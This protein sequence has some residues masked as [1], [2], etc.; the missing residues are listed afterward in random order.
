MEFRKQPRSIA[1]L[2][3][4]GERQGEINSI[5]KVTYAERVWSTQSDLETVM[6]TAAAC[7]T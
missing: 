1:K 6:H 2:V 4:N 5:D 3:N 7:T